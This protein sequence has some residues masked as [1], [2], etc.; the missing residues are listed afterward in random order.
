[1]Q[2]YNLVNEQGILSTVIDR[3]PPGSC[4]L[5]SVLVDTEWSVNGQNVVLLMNEDFGPCTV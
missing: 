2:V 4:Y 1:M 5:L 3:L